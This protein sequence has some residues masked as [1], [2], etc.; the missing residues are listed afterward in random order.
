MNLAGRIA[1]NTRYTRSTNVG[2]RPR[3][4]RDRGGIP[5]ERGRRR[6]ARRDRRHARCRRPAACMEPGRTLRLGQVLVRPVPPRTPR[7]RFGGHRR[8]ED[9]VRSQSRS[10]AAVRESRTLVPRRALGQRGADGGAPP[11]GARRRGGGALGG[12]AGPPACRAFSH[13]PRP[14]AGRDSGQR[15]PAAGGRPAGRAG[16]RRR[17]WPAPT[18]RRTRQVP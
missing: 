4:A 2:A 7:C 11:G 15:P 14:G 8:P 5:A 12:Q 18:H 17:R 10:R 16:E 1:V 9:P 3:L 13:P 6:T